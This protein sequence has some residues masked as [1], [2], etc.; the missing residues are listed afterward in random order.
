MAVD[1]PGAP[2]PF[3]C[4]TRRAL[5]PSSNFNNYPQAYLGYA[6]ELPFQ[7]GVPWGTWV[8]ALAR[9][10]YFVSARYSVSTAA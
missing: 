3:R 10:L 9:D 5:Q 1:N 4:M 6:S 8:L 2:C 7:T